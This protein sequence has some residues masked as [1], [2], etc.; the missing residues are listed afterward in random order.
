MSRTASLRL[1]TRLADWWPLL[2]APEDYAP[3]AACYREVLI[4]ACDAPPRSL[5]ELG[6]GGGNNASHLRQW[7]ALTLVDRSPQMLEVSRTLNPQCEHIRGDMRTVRLGREFDAVLVHDAVMY[8]TTRS[9]LW[10]AMRTA[11]LHCRP[12]GAALFT[13]DFVRE[14]FKPGTDH[15]GN[16]RDGRGFRYLEWTLDP[17]PKDA[18]YE[19]RY[20][21]LLKQRNGIVRGARE[22]HL[23]GL[24]PRRTWLELLVKAG[25]TPSVIR[26]G[27][28]RDC[29]V[30]RKPAANVSSPRPLPP[31][32][33]RR[34]TG[35]RGRRSGR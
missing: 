6:S 11:F 9:Q 12:G 19:V 1:Y 7:F 16:D 27:F 22:T 15:G 4:A 20:A 21:F 29:F 2:S 13:P 3:E 33:S 32:P 35:S 25:F 26:D 28:G 34:S 30:G 8:L 17:D 18:T 14:T 10:A 24:F 5:L 23:L 31:R